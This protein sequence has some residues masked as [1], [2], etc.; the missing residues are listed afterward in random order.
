MSEQPVMGTRSIGDAAVSPMALGCGWVWLFDGADDARAVELI[1]TALDCGV[2]MF[3]TARAYTTA[4]HPGYSEAMLRRA[5]ETHPRGEHVFVTTKGGHFRRGAWRDGVLAASPEEFAHEFPFDGRPEALRRHCE[6]SLELLGVERIDLY[7][8]HGID[9][10]VPLET[11]V[12]ALAELQQEGLI[13][14]IGLNSVSID[15]LERAMSVASIA[16]VQAAF[17]PRDQSNREV[18]DHCAEHSIPFLAFSALRPG[19]ND[20]ADAP[21]MSETFPKASALAREKGI[22]IERLVLAWVLSLAPTNIVVC[23]PS[24]SE[25]IRDSAQAGAVVL[26]DNELAQ[27]D[28]GT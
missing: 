25:H 3:D 2:T 24:S 13:S 12:A 11:S 21:S 14:R 10:G 6:L 27:L 4:E 20:P 7:Q 26:S 28:F 23:G 18:H 15:E 1:H 17:G 9:P 5:L 8:L 19:P 16:T 22:S